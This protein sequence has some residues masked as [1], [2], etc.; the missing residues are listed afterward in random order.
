MTT[1]SDFKARVRE[2]MA[3][4][5]E[6]YAAARAV[7]IAQ[8]NP[9]PEAPSAAVRLLPGY[10]RVGGI[11]A[12]SA[13]LANV[14]RHAGVVAP[15]TG[16]P[17]EESFL[18]GLAG[19]IG[20]MYFAFEYKNLPPMLS[21]VLRSDSYPD[22]FVRRGL[23]RSGATL[24]WHE[25]GSGTQAARH[26]DDAL[27]AD[28]S[29]ICVTDITGLPWYGMPIEYRGFAPHFAA[30]VGRG[31][32]VLA[33]DDRAARPLVISRAAF[34]EAR[35]GYRKGRH[36][37]V[38]V[39]PVGHKARAA[40]IDP[41]EVVLEAIRATARGFHEAP[42][43]G[44]GSNFGL[45]GLEKWARLIGDSRDSKGWRRLL[46]E[47]RALAAALTRMYEG[48]EVEF[49]APA[50]GRPLYAA[51][52]EEAADV[53]GRPALHGAAEIYRSAGERWSAFARATLPETEPTL[54]AIRQAVDRR[55]EN[56]DALG[57]AAAEPNRAARAEIDALQLAFAPAGD[58]RE[59][60]VADL[61]AQASAILDVERQA[62]EA[63]E[64]AI[65]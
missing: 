45:R 32:G 52:L 27:A 40:A 18:F 48:I 44:F 47:D 56:I 62:L 41:K 55:V 26:L 54:D 20:F 50:G 65:A 11:H 21:V 35:A 2:R 31:D 58:V 23:E 1:Q 64:A 25:T 22:A 42:Y 63:L 51:F 7:L 33:L 16:R 14:L 17:F 13:M 30:V 43:A 37:L 4:T 57:E 39:A 10:D 49:T 59:A 9:R 61:A 29:A 36:R 6:R 46:A 28:R 60:I 38:T 15:H 34:A 24:D 19:G 5:G 53:V 8:A 12:E 3:R